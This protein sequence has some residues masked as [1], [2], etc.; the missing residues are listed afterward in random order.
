MLLEA[1][2]RC[3]PYAVIEGIGV[4]KRRASFP[5]A[6]L[7]QAFCPKS[8]VLRQKILLHAARVMAVTVVG[9][10]EEGAEDLGLCCIGAWGI[11]A[12]QRGE[13]ECRLLL[14]SPTEMGL[15]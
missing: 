6:P 5:T 9:G 15:R 10:T 7:A 12:L 14:H 3:V 11:T 1:P 4:A 13:G 8:D 2:G